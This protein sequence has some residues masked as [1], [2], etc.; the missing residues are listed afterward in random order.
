MVSSKLKIETELENMNSVINTLL[1]ERSKKKRTKIELAGIATY[2]HNFYNGVENILKQI[3]KTKAI[4]IE[5]SAY[6]HKELLERSVKEKI[7]SKSLAVSLS[8]F[9]SFRHFFVHSY[10]FILNEQKLKEL[11]K[12]V[13]KTYEKL[14]EEIIPYIES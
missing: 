13:F 6:W 7:I 11:H 5:D 9:M 14:K 1:E 10:S 8:E 3:L 12:K 4:E 2:I